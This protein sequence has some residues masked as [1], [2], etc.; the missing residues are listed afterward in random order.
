MVSAHLVTEI[1]SF[2]R[3][4][5]LDR[6]TNEVALTDGTTRE[7]IENVVCQW[8][9]R[10]MSMSVQ[11][12]DHDAALFD[13]GIDSLGAMSIA[14]ALED[15]TGKKLNPE[16]IYELDTIRLIGD[17]LDSVSALAVSAVDRHQT[18]VQMCCQASLMVSDDVERCILPANLGSGLFCK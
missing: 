15:T 8:L 14:A 18:Y 7:L 12:I 5:A 9:R 16:L 17:H 6:P 4:T 10:E 2:L 3:N 11:K 1:E 13:L